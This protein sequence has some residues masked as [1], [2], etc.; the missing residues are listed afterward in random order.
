MGSR[1]RLLRI[2]AMLADG[3][4]EVEEQFDC[5]DVTPLYVHGSPYP[6]EYVRMP[7]VETRRRIVSDEWEIKKI[8]RAL[9]AKDR[10]SSDPDESLL[11]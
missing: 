4:I 2:T 8:V 11:G 6:R 10:L 5:V 9:Q 7:G 1:G 3:S